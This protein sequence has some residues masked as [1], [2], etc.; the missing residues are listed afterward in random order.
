MTNY[1][2]KYLAHEITRRCASDS[3]E[4]L[5]AVLSDAQVDLNPH[6]I[7]AALFAFRNP[8]SR[9]AI[10]ADEVGLGKT[11]EAGL[12]IAQMW[13]ERKRR[14]L[15]IA[16]ANLRKQWSQELADKFFLP[17]AILETRTFNEGIRAGNLNPFQCDGAVICSYQF[18][19]SK[20]PYV[21]QTAWDLVVVDEAHRLRNVYKPA[22]KISRA[23]KQAI[24][25]YQKALLTATPL[26]N[27][28][29]ELYGLVS[30]IDEFTFGGLKS[31]RA[32]FARLAG[33]ADFAELKQRL[34]P[35][36]KRTLRKQVLEYIKYT[37]R[38]ALV[39]EFMPS[40]DEQRLYNLV[41]DYLQKNTL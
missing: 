27:S 40:A 41:S 38:H 6:Q 32:Q 12:L 37:N 14:L 20:E 33:D 25:P 16:P 10:L 28:L 30:I 2:A 15:V 13:A 29:L 7:D 8:L 21:R 1:H 39:Q 36:C 26:Q 17:S 3:V 22:N 11:I 35:I 4:K 9:G 5:T 24:F 31:F 19:R 18:A 34:K 23:I